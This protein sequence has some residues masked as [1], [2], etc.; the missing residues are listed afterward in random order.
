MLMTDL[1]PAVV[2]SILRTD[3]SA[4]I[5]VWVCV[6][7]EGWPKICADVGV[8]EDGRGWPKLCADVGMCEDGRGWS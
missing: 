1:F 4:V 5:Q 7:R 6:R 8:C 3:D 2:Q